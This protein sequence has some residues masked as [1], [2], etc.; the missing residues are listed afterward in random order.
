MGSA[1]RSSRKKQGLTWLLLVVL[2]TTAPRVRAE[3]PDE[4]V[5]LDCGINALF[6]LLHLEG[7]PVALERLLSALP[8]RQPAGYSM[9]EL[10]AASRSCGLVLEG[11]R[12]QGG[13]RPLRHAAIAF[14][15]DG[16]GG[17]FTV[18]RPVGNTG[19]MVQVIDPPHVPRVVDYD[20]IVTA[21]AWTGQILVPRDGPPRQAVV[22][23]SLAVTGLIGLVVGRLRRSHR[24]GRRGDEPTHQ[25]P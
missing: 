16:R 15:Q 21:R 5:R 23:A 17:H 25:G 13:V 10:A 7:R 3:G 20:R 24:Q 11:V 14:L 4:S 9:A 1:A 18:L 12:F 19:T 2:G 22:L 8:A 6:I